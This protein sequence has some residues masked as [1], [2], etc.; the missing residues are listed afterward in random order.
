MTAIATALQGCAYNGLSMGIGTDF[1]IGS[2]SASSS[3]SSIALLGA[4]GLSGL[5]DLPS[6]RSSDAPRAQDIGVWQ[7]QDFLDARTVHLEVQVIAADNATMYADIGLL[8]QAF[9][10]QQTGEI[11]LYLFNNQRQI[12]C[13]VRSRSIPYDTGNSPRIGGMTVELLASDPRIYDATLQSLVLIPSS[14]TVGASW[15]WSWNLSWGGASTSGT[16]T[17]VNS[18]NYPTRPIITITGPCTNPYLQNVTTGALLS[19]QIALGVSDT[20]VIDL[21]ARSI[22]L[23][24]S[25]SKRSALVSGSTW[26]Q[27]APGSTGLKFGASS[28][29]GSCQATVAFRNAWI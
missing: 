23:N 24:G 10:P 28:F 11:P 5:D 17:A 12:N 16:G 15:N 21:D 14:G 13:R 2:L 4:T 18:G 8:E 3:G 19:F 29:S 20:L 6:I 9:Q 25:T 22:V 27:L 26:W 7:G 1:H